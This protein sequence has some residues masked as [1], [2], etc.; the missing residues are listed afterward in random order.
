MESN[1]T[2][3]LRDESV[4][5]DDSVLGNALG[6]SYKSYTALLKVFSDND[7]KPEWRY[8][9]D[10]KAWLCKVEQKKKTVVWISVHSGF[11]VAALYFPVRLMEQVYE[12][13]ISD[14]L[15][16]KIKLTKSVGKLHPCVFEIR[17]ES[18]LEDLKRVM[19]FKMTA[20]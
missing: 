7:L 8:Y 4:Y 6:D 10:G 2:L 15:K 14:S 13:D 3:E 16:Q 18:L 20:K 19:M 1:E 9:K 12:L 5:P 11:L 17:D